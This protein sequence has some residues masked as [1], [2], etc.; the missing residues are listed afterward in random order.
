MS[1]LPMAPRGAREP[2]PPTF[3]EADERLEA[4]VAFLDKYRFDKSNRQAG[5]A[6]RRLSADPKNGEPVW[7]T[8]VGPIR[9]PAGRLAVIE[10]LAAR[11][12]RAS[13][14]PDPGY[15]PADAQGAGD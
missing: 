12:H 15:R 9:G 13:F 7:Q 5:E 8:E 4:R 14:G 1:D 11:E 3:D 2:G 10:E 6:V